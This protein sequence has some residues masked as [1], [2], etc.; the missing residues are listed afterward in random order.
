MVTSVNAVFVDVKSLGSAK[1][2]GSQIRNG[3]RFFRAKL[4]QHSFGSHCYESDCG[5]RKR[6]MGVNH[7]DG[8]LCVIC[9]G[10]MTR[11]ELTVQEN[12]L[13]D[14][15]G[16]YAHVVVADPQTATGFNYH[17][18][19]FD[20]SLG[21]SDLQVVLP[22]PNKQCHSIAKTIYD[23][24]KSGKS[25]RNG[26]EITI[27]NQSGSQFSARFIKV[28]EGDRDVLRVILPGPGGGLE[29]KHVGDDDPEYALQ[30]TVT[31]V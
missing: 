29:P 30:W 7:E 20:K 11:K 8:C 10:E 31:A 27:P 14:Q 15:Y 24:I 6:K 4:Q 22:L 5:V 12:Q 9:S 16:W 17:T 13:M 25:F 2:A 19:G 3:L 1:E 28:R 21:H 26:D 18:H 23:Q